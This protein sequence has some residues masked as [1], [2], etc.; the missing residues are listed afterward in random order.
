MIKKIINFTSE[1]CTP[2]IQFQ[3]TFENVSKQFENIEFLTINI[4]DENS[5]DIID[6]YLIKRVPSIII[7]DDKE[8]LIYKI[9]GKISENE[10]I[11]I[12]TDVQ[13]NKRP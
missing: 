5:E 13:N 4:E 2:C 6:K 11:E 8:N 10:L 3:P 7:L 9:L 1:N 12:I